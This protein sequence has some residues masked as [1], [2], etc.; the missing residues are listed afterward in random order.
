MPQLNKSQGHLAQTEEIH[1]VKDK[2]QEVIREVEMHQ[3]SRGNTQ[4]INLEN[5]MKKVETIRSQHQSPGETRRMK[6]KLKNIGK[7]NKRVTIIR[8]KIPKIKMHNKN[9]LSRIEKR[10]VLRNQ[11]KCTIR[12]NK[13]N[14]ILTCLHHLQLTQNLELVIKW[15]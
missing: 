8:I 14:L 15:H 10:I 1:Q 11:R 2:N 3:I 6:N 12:K 5:K 4:E 7:N 13:I 9:N